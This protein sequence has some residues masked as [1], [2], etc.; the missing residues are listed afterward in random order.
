MH[1]SPRRWQSIAVT[2]LL[3]L[4]AGAIVWYFRAR[5]GGNAGS[6]A[7]TE[8]TTSTLAEF[9]QAAERLYASDNIYYGNARK[10][11]YEG[12]LRQ[13]LPPETRIGA[14]VILSREYLRLGEVDSAIATM[15]EA[16]RLA[17]TTPISDGIRRGLVF[18]RG[19]A[20]WRLGS[21]QNCIG[22]HNKKTCLF[23]IPA[24]GVHASRAPALEARK[25]FE[26]YVRRYPDD[27]ATAGWMLNLI[28][29]ALGDFPRAVPREHRLPAD[30]FRSGADIGRFEDM[31]AELGVNSFNL[32]GG[33]IAED[34]DGDGLLDIVFSTAD[35]ESA[36][37][38]FRNCGEAGF[39]NATAGSGLEDQLGGLN[40][41]GADYD[42]D[43]DVDILVLRGGWLEDNGQI[44]KSLLRN[45]GDGTFTDVTREAGFAESSMPTQAAAWGDFDNDGD[46]DL[47][48]ANENPPIGPLKYPAQLF[49]ND[50]RGR[51]TDIAL[52]AGVRN[53]RFGKA[54][55]AGDYDNDGDLDIYV[56][57][58]GEN[59]LYRNEGDMTFVDVAPALGMTEPRGRSF[60]SWWFDF[61]NDG[62]LDLFV[63][64]YSATVGDLADDLRGRPVTAGI[65]RLYR[66]NRDGTFADVTRAAGLAH[67]SLPMGANFGDFDNDGWLDM[68]LGTGDPYYTTL[69]PNVAYLNR[70]GREFLD[71]S[72]SGDLGHLEKGHGTAF[73]DFDNDGD[74]DIF[75][76]RGGFYRGDAFFNALLVN[77][78]HGNRFLTLSLVGTKTNALAFG[79]RIK[80]VVRTPE[81][82]REI[83]RAVGSVSSFGGS[84]FRQEIGL[85]NAVAILRVE[86]YWPTSR[87][88]QVFANVPLD[89]FLRIT[90]GKDSYETFRPSR[91]DLA[92]LAAR[93]SA[94][95]LHP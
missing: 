66:N 11:E 9:Q 10:R 94:R 64:A 75:Q 67:P 69:T 52:E 45:N 86:V 63:A 13:G 37:T 24:A 43:G 50:G 65:P 2:G 87:T 77:P 5:A 76:Q 70:E 56:S 23:P 58:I 84:P 55:V 80:V 91:F 3:V 74:Q 57:N 81:G 19:L 68:Y 62:W 83:H 26:E 21:V 7:S 30:V 1:V 29:M 22:G 39:A 73:A 27:A 61:D 28:A 82:T 78:G 59:R 34:F 53:E 79:A 4:L 42:D 48:V 20:Y 40:C 33:A 35:P 54:A 46:L 15:E 60:T 92:V 71:I 90:E 44:R 93:G 25:S 36:L 6:P 38:F 14:L 47:Y 51:F 32:A 18:S 8:S 85:G 16:S 31:G 72:A 12:K 95:H 17:A 88:R 49:R 41:I 89:A